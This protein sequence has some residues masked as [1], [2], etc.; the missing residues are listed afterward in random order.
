MLA[1][2][3]GVKLGVLK[4]KVPFTLA[5]PRVKAMVERDPPSLPSAAIGSAVIVGVALAIEKSIDLLAE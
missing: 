3:G 1:P 4:A 2:A 5:L